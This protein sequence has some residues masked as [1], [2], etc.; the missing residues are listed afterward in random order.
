M[1]PVAAESVVWL[2]K[3]SQNGN[4]NASVVLDLVRGSAV[5]AEGEA[6]VRHL[7]EERRD[8][9]DLVHAA[10]NSPRCVF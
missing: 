5:T 8:V 1:L 7:L 3:E 2:G 4:V 6:Q 10:A 9:M